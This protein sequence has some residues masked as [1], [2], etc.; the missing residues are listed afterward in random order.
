M[1]S[2]LLLAILSGCAN[3]MQA[4]P[5]DTIFAD[6]HLFG[7]TAIAYSADGQTLYSGGFKGE[8]RRW[9]VAG[10]KPIGLAVAHTDA[11]RAIVPVSTDTYAT[12][13]DDG[14]IVLWRGGRVVA[15][16][17][18]AAV[19]ALALF[20]GK[21]VSAHARGLR[22]WSVDALKALG[23]VPMPKGVVALSVRTGRLAVGMSHGVALLDEQ[24]HTLKT[25]ESGGTHDVQFSPDGKTL[26]AGG[27]FRLYLWDVDSGAM[28]SVPTEHN[29][30]LTSLAWSPDGRQLVTLGRH[31]DSAI[32]VLD[33]RDYSVVQRY[34]AHA[35]CGAM[36]R[37]S[38]DGRHLASA[39]DDESV[40][41]YTFNKAA[42]GH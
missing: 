25:F 21:L 15:Q 3:L 30:L 17:Q 39:S 27:W 10:K 16:Q 19:T 42:S 6:A 4:D 7:S 35:L 32:R 41:L 33:T 31:T 20:Q 22:I 1:L 37:F 14:R 5:A 36:I 24:M 2:L 13:G 29:G 23:E 8:V 26:A 34:Q 38:P 11:V 40:R 28:R 9:D 12:A 18:T